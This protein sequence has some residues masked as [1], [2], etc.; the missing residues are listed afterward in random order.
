MTIPVG[1]RDDLVIRGNFRPL[2]LIFRGML[3]QKGPNTVVAVANDQFIQYRPR[4]VVMGF[5]SPSGY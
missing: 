3:M 5:D 4:M 1:I 2:R